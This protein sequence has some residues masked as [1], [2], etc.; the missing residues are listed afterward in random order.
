MKDN[1]ERAYEPPTAPTI[2]KAHVAL[3]I[4]NIVDWSMS[5]ISLYSLS[6]WLETL[7]DL[8]II[9]SGLILFYIY[10]GSKFK[11]RFYFMLYPMWAAV[12]LFV[13]L[14]PNA[15]FADAKSIFID[16]LY[17]DHRVFS[18]GLFSIYDDSSGLLSAC[19]PYMVSEQKFFF[20]QKDIGRFNLSSPI[21]PQ[22]ISLGDG[23]LEEVLLYFKEEEDSPIQ[24][25]R[26]YT[27]SGTVTLDEGL[28]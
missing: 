16:P 15:K 17:S 5:Q 18:E 14:L 26:I 13:G 11:K 3:L 24:L 19:C 27:K 22:K 9:A 12:L 4:L 6:H 28:P 8:L 2:L 23:D 21:L 10:Y 7:I 25:L 20:F 1:T